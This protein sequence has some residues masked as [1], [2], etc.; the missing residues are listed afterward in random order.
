[1]IKYLAYLLLAVWEVKTGNSFVFGELI[2]CCFCIA[3][4]GPVVELFYTVNITGIAA[5]IKNSH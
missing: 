2:L 5:A 1:M 4:E 3:E